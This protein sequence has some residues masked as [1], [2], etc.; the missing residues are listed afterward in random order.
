MLR[1]L[2]HIL[3]IKLCFLY[4][5]IRKHIYLLIHFPFDPIRSDE[6]IIVSLTSWSKR[7][8]NIPKVIDSILENT[9]L[10]DI[11]VINLSL[12]EF[13]NKENDIPNEVVKYIKKHEIEII[14]SEK[15]DKAYKKFIPTML[16]YPNDAIICIDDDFIYPKDFISTFVKKHKEFP[17]N[18]LSGNDVFIWGIK[19]HCGCAS[20]VKKRYFGPY[21]EELL[22][23]KCIEIGTSDIFFTLCAALNYS[24]YIYVGKQFFFNMESFNS[25]SGLTDSNFKTNMNNMYKHLIQKIHKKYHINAST[26]HLL[27]FC[28]P[29]SKNTL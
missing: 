5:Y 24:D 11:I 10:P 25:I 27:Y 2:I 6:K 23:E 3:N 21:I 19:A 14:W 4:L 17:K 28:N 1:K 20:L 15:N 7:I 12:Q 18:P 16:K 8:S 22:D 29:F 13:P 9:T 26:P